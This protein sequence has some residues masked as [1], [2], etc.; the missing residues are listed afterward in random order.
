VQKAHISAVQYILD[1]TDIDKIILLPA[2]IAPHKQKENDIAAF[3]HRLKMLRIASDTLIKDKKVQIS[4]IE[5]KLPAPS[6]TINTL[7]KLSEFCKDEEPSLI[8]GRDMYNILDEWKDAKLLAET[9]R[10]II[11][12]R[13]L[14]DI[15]N[16]KIKS[17]FK[18]KPIFL[19]NPLWEISS[20][21]V[22]RLFKEYYLKND[23]KIIEKLKILLPEEVIH[24]ILKE[25]LYN[26]A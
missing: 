9:Y 12:N 7:K 24:Y 22:R 18:Y 21:K 26:D 13:K 8:I 14:S 25:N 17:M 11:L 5:K 19:K 3:R 23:K 20:T 1:N 15:E 4:I 10:F 16:E 2:F 6:Y